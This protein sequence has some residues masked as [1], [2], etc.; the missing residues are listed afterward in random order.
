MHGGAV[1]PVGGHGADDLPLVNI[2]SPA[3]DN[4]VHNWLD[5]RKVNSRVILNINV[6]VVLDTINYFGVIAGDGERFN[7]GGAHESP[8]LVLWVKSITIGKVL[9]ASDLDRFRQV[10]HDGIIPIYL[11]DVLLVVPIVRY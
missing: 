5:G 4:G 8:C 11:G 10:S 2:R 3:S 9:I 1:L 7:L 6:M